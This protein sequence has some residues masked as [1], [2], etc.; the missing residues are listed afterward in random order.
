MDN[1]YTE[2]SNITDDDYKKEMLRQ[3]RLTRKYTR[4][5]YKNV[6]FMFYAG[7]AVTI[8]VLYANYA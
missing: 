7:L 5:I 8:A 6:A 2:D 1:T 3:A 4:L